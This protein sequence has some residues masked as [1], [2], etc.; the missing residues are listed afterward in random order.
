MVHI[1]PPLITR[2]SEPGGRDVCVCVCACVCV[3][4]CVYVFVRFVGSK[5]KGLRVM[6]GYLS[7]AV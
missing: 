5:Q 6:A 4:V 7:I 2:S 1:L 3:C